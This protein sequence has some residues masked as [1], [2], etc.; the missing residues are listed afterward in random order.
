M[1]RQ[2]L[3]WA[4]GAATAALIVLGCNGTGSGLI[5][6]ATSGGGNDTTSLQVT[7][8]IENFAFNPAVVHLTRGGVVTW[9]WSADTVSHNVTFAD[10]A[11]SSPTQSVGT[12]TVVFNDQGTFTYRCTI[13]SGMNGSIVVR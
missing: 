11:L 2:S 9:V 1:M 13:H 8:R 5:G 7:V 10:P 6:I 3:T 12:H 4:V